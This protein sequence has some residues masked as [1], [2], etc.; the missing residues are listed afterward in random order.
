MS[1][2]LLISFFI[3]FF[4]TFRIRDFHQITAEKG[5]IIRKHSIE[6]EIAKVTMCIR[7]FFDQWQIQQTNT[8]MEFRYQFLIGRNELLTHKLI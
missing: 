5:R 4:R 6:D 3:I 1:N 2:S 7:I 8:V